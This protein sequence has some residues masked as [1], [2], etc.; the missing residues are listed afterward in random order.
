MYIYIYIQC[1]HTYITN[2]SS[3]SL[4]QG[5]HDWPYT[6]PQ[7]VC[8]FL[9]PGLPQ[10]LCHRRR[11]RFGDH[12]APPAASSAVDAEGENGVLVK[13]SPLMHPEMGRSATQH[14][15]FQ[16]EVSCWRDWY[17][18]MVG[19]WVKN[20]QW[21]L[22]NGCHGSSGTPMTC[23]YPYWKSLKYIYMN[24]IEYWLIKHDKKQCFVAGY[25]CQSYSIII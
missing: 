25:C 3:S 14:P 5:I 4:L 11:S 13:S 6:A 18:L 15:S 9:S 1:T 8:D 19:V 21:T 17:G 7:W 2:L 22:Q 20:H 23:P 10:K 24:I 16:G 12:R